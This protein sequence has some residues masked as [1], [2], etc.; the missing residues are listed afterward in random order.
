[1]C[2]TWKK[3]RTAGVVEEPEDP[4]DQQEEDQ[5]EEFRVGDFLCALYEKKFY[6]GRLMTLMQCAS[7]H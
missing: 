6:I 3:G 2:D 1:M 7:T 5:E 4:E